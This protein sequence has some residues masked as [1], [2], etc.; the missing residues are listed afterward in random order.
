M[1]ICFKC[2]VDFKLMKAFKNHMRYHGITPKSKIK[3]VNGN[4]GGLEFSHI[5]NFERHFKKKHKNLRKDNVRKVEENFD[6]NDKSVD[7]PITSINSENVSEH[8]ED[9]LEVLS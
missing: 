7:D 5:G 4:C 1:P 9:S 2:L 6:S 8:I 3:C